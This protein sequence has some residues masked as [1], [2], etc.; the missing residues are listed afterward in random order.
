[1]IYQ[2]DNN[3][4]QSNDSALNTS[5]FDTYPILSEIFSSEK[6]QGNF[7]IN[8]GN[9]GSSKTIFL[10]KLDYDPL[11]PDRFIV[12]IMSI[13]FKQIIADT[14]PV[15]DKSILLGFFLCIISCLVAIGFSRRL[16]RPLKLMTSS[17]RDFA[18]GKIK[19]LHVIDSDDEVGILSVAFSD[20][21][22]DLNNAINK[23][24]DHILLFTISFSR[25]I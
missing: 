8:S 2:S 18:N 3:S 7:K 1:M 10:Q 22:R 19:K 9:E 11:S 24:M 12:L 4:D 15:R 16:T 25:N 6:S 14:L 17:I 13:P 23:N 21:T 20:M 5:I